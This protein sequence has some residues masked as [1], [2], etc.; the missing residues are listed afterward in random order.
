MQPNTEQLHF[1]LMQ[2]DQA[3]SEILS[4]QGSYLSKDLD[5]AKRKMRF[6]RGTQSLKINPLIASKAKNQFLIILESSQE[7]D[8]EQRCQLKPQRKRP[9]LFAMR[10]HMER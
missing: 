4:L 10:H 6:F 5:S 9:M 3:R 1:K 8:T 2:P 7:P